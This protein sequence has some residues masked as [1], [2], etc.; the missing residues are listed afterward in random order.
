MD[1]HGRVRWLMPVIPALWEAEV[2]RSLE[3]SGR[4]ALPL[5]PQQSLS[6]TKQ[7]S[8]CG[9]TRVSLLSPRLEYNGAILAHCRLRVPGSSN[10]PAS[11]S[12]VA[13]I[14]DARHHTRLIFVFF[15]EM[16]FHHICQA[17]LEL[18]TSSDPPASASQSAGITGGQQVRSSALLP[19]TGPGPLPRWLSYLL[20]FILDLVICLM[21]CLGLAKRSKCLLAS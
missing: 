20:L 12:R 21:A 14:T 18:L 13:G 16:G 8:S 19:L 5:A 4:G 9:D 15:V 10:S 3:R 17:G 6:L 1:G 7:Q 2:G 11:A